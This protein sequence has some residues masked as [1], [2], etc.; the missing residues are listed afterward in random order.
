MAS[1]MAALRV[2]P[3]HSLTASR[4]APLSCKNFRTNPADSWRSVNNSSSGRA[5]SAPPE[6]EA[7][8]QK[9]EGLAPLYEDLG[10][11]YMHD[12][13]NSRATEAFKRA[14]DNALAQADAV[15]G[16][17]DAADKRC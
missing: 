16:D 1:I 2:K 3:V 11:A 17:K 9:E 14:I 6:F 12:A 13:Q 4:L 5:G 7:A 10:Y 15:D 8:L